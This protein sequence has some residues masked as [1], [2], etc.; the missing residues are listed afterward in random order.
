VLVSIST[1]L[2][3]NFYDF[4]LRVLGS[5]AMRAVFSYLIRQ[6]LIRVGL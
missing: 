4:L 5:E 1:I 3:I 6:T 2:G